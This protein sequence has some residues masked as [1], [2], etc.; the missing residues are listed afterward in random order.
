MLVNNI[1]MGSFAA[2][3]LFSDVNRGKFF[4]VQQMFP[5]ITIPCE[6]LQLANMLNN[7]LD[8]DTA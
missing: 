1:I 2:S 4:T 5:E 8:H 7:S 3:V 6:A